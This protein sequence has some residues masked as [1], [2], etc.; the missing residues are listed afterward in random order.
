MSALVYLTLKSNISPGTLE[1]N[2]ECL[3]SYLVTSG[4]RTKYAGNK[5]PDLYSDNSRPQKI[6]KVYNLLRAN[7]K[8][9][10]NA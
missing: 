4:I 9:H 2:Y 10:E 1:E 7:G 3:Q 6:V 8:S 5:S